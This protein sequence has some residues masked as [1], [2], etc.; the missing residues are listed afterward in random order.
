MVKVLGGVWERDPIVLFKNFE[1]FFTSI[2]FCF[3]IVLM[4]KWIFKNK[5]KNI[6]LQKHFEKQPLPLSQTPF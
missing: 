2:V 3:W 1:F 5:I 6:I 4:L